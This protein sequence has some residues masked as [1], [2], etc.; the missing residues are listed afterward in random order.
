[1]YTVEQRYAS[2]KRGVIYFIVYSTVLFLTTATNF[3]NIKTFFYFLVGFTLSGVIAVLFMATQ[4]KIEEKLKPNFWILNIIIEIIG[5]Y[6]F[7]QIIF[8]LFF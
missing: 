2:Y 8:S 3:L 1:M 5:Y 7:T 4:Y 6:I